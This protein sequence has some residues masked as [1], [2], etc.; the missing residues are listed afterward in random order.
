VEESARL[1]RDVL[2]WE[3]DGVAF[4]LEGDLGKD[5]AVELAESVR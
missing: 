1:A 3:R 4:R 5:E 2:I